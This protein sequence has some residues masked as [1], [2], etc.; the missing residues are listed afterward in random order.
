MP[1]AK[2]FALQHF[3]NASL[4]R[5]IDKCRGL[6]ACVYAKCRQALHML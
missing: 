4:R 6:K 3:S 1:A 2:R 5:M